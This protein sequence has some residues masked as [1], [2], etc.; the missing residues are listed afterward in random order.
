M[1]MVSFVR[2]ILN[3]AISL[4][5][6]NNN[7]LSRFDRDFPNRISQHPALCFKDIYMKILIII[8][9]IPIEI[10]TILK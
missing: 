4:T 3:I 9:P 8:Y 10:Y 2:M 5:L 6:R 7:L 1:Y